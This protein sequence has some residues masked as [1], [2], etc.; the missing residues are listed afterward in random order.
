MISPELLRRYPFFSCFSH[1]QLADLAMAADEVSVAADY[2]FFDEGELLN[3]FFLLQEGNVALT[4]K[5]PDRNGRNTIV[6]H[7]TG[8]LFTETIKVGSLGKQDVFGWSA[9][10]PPHKSTAGAEAE[11]PCQ[12]I[13]VDMGRLRPQLKKDLQFANLLTLKG[14]QIIRER[15]RMRRIEMLAG[16]V[17]IA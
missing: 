10:I 16:Y 11:E 15:L 12:I 17:E 2:C 13:A 1:E 3:R 4:V 14:A 8:D 5:V 7:L 6:N 9:L